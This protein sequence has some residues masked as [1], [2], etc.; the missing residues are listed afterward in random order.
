MADLLN[1]TQAQDRELADEL[2]AHHAVMVD[3][4]DRLTTDLLA[5]TGDAAAAKEP[6]IE[7]VHEVLLPHAAE[8]ESTTYAAAAGLSEGAALIDVLTR[9]H[10]TITQLAGAFHASDDLALAAGYA[11]S[12]FHVFQ[13]HQAK[14]NEIVIPM[15]LAA[16]TVSLSAVV[17]A[18]PAEHHHHH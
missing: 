18:G 11:R 2:L 6:L 15:L 7:W 14:E 13:A 5:A 17:A 12:L 1:T 10:G 9:E 3:Q 16:P 8:E 4:L